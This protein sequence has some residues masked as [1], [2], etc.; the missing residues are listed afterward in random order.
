MQT[1][2]RPASLQAFVARARMKKYAVEL[3]S[4]LPP[5]YEITI[6]ARHKT[7]DNANLIVSQDQLTSAA[8]ALTGAWLS[9]RVKFLDLTFNGAKPVA[10]QVE[11]PIDVCTE[12]PS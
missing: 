5:D 9:E 2:N 11:N 10:V 4:L 12:Q 6:I 3:A 7:I 1:D 8:D